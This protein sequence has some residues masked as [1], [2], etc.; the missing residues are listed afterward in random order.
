MTGRE[1]SFIGGGVEERLTREGG[2]GVKG[3]EEE[4]DAEED[5]GRL[6]TLCGIVPELLWVT[7]PGPAR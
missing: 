4:E 3:L 1:R 5:I 7:E 6:E 2:E